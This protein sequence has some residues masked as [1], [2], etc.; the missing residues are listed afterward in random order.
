MS[1]KA[2][3]RRDSKKAS[4]STRAWPIE[5][6]KQEFDRFLYGYATNICSTDVKEHLISIRLVEKL[7][8]PDVTEQHGPTEA[9]IEEA[10]KTG[11]LAWPTHK[12]AVPA[13]TFLFEEDEKDLILRRLEKNIGRVPPALGAEFEVLRQK[14]IE[15]ES[16]EVSP[17]D[18]EPEPEEVEP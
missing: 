9:E 16:I 3:R 6:T 14:F 5:V 18:E 12:L 2:A 11:G 8:D 17:P 10:E 7:Q 13:H 1:S 15:A 4:K